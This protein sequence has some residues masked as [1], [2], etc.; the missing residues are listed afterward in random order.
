MKQ[1]HS[2]FCPSFIWSSQPILWI[3]RCRI[4]YHLFTIETGGQ[5]CRDVDINQS[6]LQQA[7]WWCNAL[8]LPGEKM[9]W[10][11]SIARSTWLPALKKVIAEKK[12]FSYDHQN[13][14]VWSVYVDE[15]LMQ[16]TEAAPTVLISLHHAHRAVG[17][18][19][20]IL[21]IVKTL[22]N[23]NTLRQE[24]VQQCSWSRQ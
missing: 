20:D 4:P 5:K 6:T 8:Q 15:T 1:I 23:Q 18:Q 12:C 9:L 21:R 13:L 17:M 2:K 22:G 16:W 7:A 10:N 19:K 3:W 11:P 14:D 24:K